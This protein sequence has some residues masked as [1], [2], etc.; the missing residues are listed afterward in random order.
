MDDVTKDQSPSEII[1][2][3]LIDS[4]NT[5]IETPSKDDVDP[6][7]IDTMTALNQP[8]SQDNMPVNVGLLVKDIIY[9]N[10]GVDQTKLKP[11]TEKKWD[12]S[13][14]EVM[15]DIMLAD[16]NREGPYKPGEE[17]DIV[18]NDYRTGGTGARTVQNVQLKDGSTIDRVH[19]DSLKTESLTNLIKDPELRVKLSLGSYKGSMDKDGNY[20]IK[21][22]FNFNDMHGEIED[23]KLVNTDVPLQY[24]GKRIEIDG[25]VKYVAGKRKSFTER[26]KQAFAPRIINSKTGQRGKIDSEFGTY[27]GVNYN[28]V[29]TVARWL[30]SNKQDEGRRI[31]INLGKDLK[32]KRK[33]K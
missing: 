29:R 12:S 4:G 15:K 9:S 10:L 16:I 13:D 14:L 3:R 11:Y 1:G 23:N 6:G 32:P 22:Q 8:E 17:R 7:L 2:Q 25:K 28:S 30:G 31:E 26:F 27:P 18:Y 33:T 21:D 24:E 19:P 5:K 20:I